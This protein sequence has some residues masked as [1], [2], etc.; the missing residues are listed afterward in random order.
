MRSRVSQNSR[1]NWLVAIGLSTGTAEVIEKETEGMSKR[2]KISKQVM[3]KYVVLFQD[4]I[5]VLFYSKYL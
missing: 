4:A 3:V 5:A 2:P 1:A